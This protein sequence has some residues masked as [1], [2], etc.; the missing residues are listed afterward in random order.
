MKNIPCPGKNK[1]V[2]KLTIGLNTSKMKK[3]MKKWKKQT[4][5]VIEKTLKEEIRSYVATKVKIKRE[6]KVKEKRKT[7]KMKKFKRNL[8]SK[9]MKS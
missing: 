8:F 1:K 9:E 7:E 2:W 3:P 5:P 4:F 6:K